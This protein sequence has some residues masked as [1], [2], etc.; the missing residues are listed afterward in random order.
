MEK[1]SP[2]FA[3]FED[4]RNV[5]VLDIGGASGHFIRKLVKEFSNLNIHATVFDRVEYENWNEENGEISYISG[6]AE[7]LSEIFSKESFDVVFVNRLYH[8]LVSDSLKKTFEIMN[9]VTEEIRLVMKKD[10]LLCITD[11]L[12][13]G[14]IIDSAPCRLIFLLSSSKN[15]LVVRLCRGFGSMSAGVGVCMRSEKMWL[16]MFEKNSLKIQSFERGE[17]HDFSLFMR[18]VLL[19]RQYSENSVFILKEK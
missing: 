1:Y 18:A 9:R 14:F 3:G 5:E 2:V 10:A 15:K 12:C 11:N 8:H 13:S 16:K 7:S 4:G 19:I 6:A 17:E